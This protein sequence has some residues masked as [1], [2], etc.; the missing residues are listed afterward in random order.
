M[1]VY[2][3]Y[4]SG[5]HDQTYFDKINKQ[6]NDEKDKRMIINQLQ[7]Q[8]NNQKRNKNSIKHVKL[9]DWI[10]SYFNNSI[11]FQGFDSILFHDKFIIIINNYQSH[12]ISSISIDKFG[13][14]LYENLKLNP[15]S[16]FWPSCENLLPSYKNLNSRRALAITNLKDSSKLINTNE[17]MNL[18]LWDETN[19]GNL[20]NLMKLI[21]HQSSNYIGLQLLKLG[22]LQQHSLNSLFIDVIY[23]N[24]NNNEDDNNKFV[25]LLGEQLEQL[26]DP[27]LEYCPERVQNSYVP[28]IQ[29]SVSSI[30]NNSTIQSIIEELISVQTNYTI[31]LVNLLQNFIIPLRI[32]IVNNSKSSKNL[33]KIN[34]IFPPTI[35]EITRINCI[36]NDSLLKAQKINYLQVFKSLSIILPQFYKPFIRHEANVKKFGSELIKFYHHNKIEIFENLTINVNGLSIREIDSIITGSLLELSKI[37]LII[38]RL[39]IAI[40]SEKL[41]IRNFDQDINDTK[42]DEEIEKYSKII[43]E[44]IDA[45][46][47]ENKQDQEVNRDR[48]F[49]PSGKFLVELAT[50]W[51]KELQNGWI[52]RKLIGIFEMENLQCETKCN[53]EVLII[54]SDYLLILNISDHE[55]YESNKDISISIPDVLMHSLINE[56]PLPNIDRFPSMEVKNWCL[57]NE[58]LP[59]S[60]ECLTE[61][62]EIIDCLRILNTT[63]S[64]FNATEGDQVFTKHYKVLN[65]SSSNVI[66]LIIKANV[67][68]KVSPFHLFK[69]TDSNLNIYYTAHE[70]S[71]YVQE[72]SKSN[73]L[74]CLNMDIDVPS[75]FQSNPNLRFLLQISFIDEEKVRVTGYD[76]ICNKQINEVIQGKNLNEFIKTMIYKNF[77][78]LVSTYNDVTKNLIK[79]NEKSLRFIIDY[80]INDQVI[81]NVH[82]PKG[83]NTQYSISGVLHES[84]KN[85]ENK[86]VEQSKV[87]PPKTEKKR[88]SLFGNLFKV[89]Q[90]KI[91]TS[92]DSTNNISHT[93]IPRGTKK[94]YVDYYKP[95]PKLRTRADSNSSTITRPKEVSKLT[96]LLGKE[97]RYNSNLETINDNDTSVLRNEKL[98]KSNNHVTQPSIEISEGFSFPQKPIESE[99]PTTS[100]TIKR[101]STF[102]DVSLP[103]IEWLLNYTEADSQPN[104]E[105]ICSN[106]VIN[107]RTPI[108]EEKLES[109]ESSESRIPSNPSSI[110]SST[111]KQR[112]VSPPMPIIQQ[113]KREESIQSITSQ[114]YINHFEKFINFEFENENKPTKKDLQPFH[115]NNSIITLTSE[116][117]GHVN[118]F[119]DCRIFYSPIEELGK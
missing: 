11:V 54:F 2:K 18:P 38:E 31:G 4:V 37:K 109:S 90:V 3:R 76:K 108:I 67:L 27:L 78:G 82:L 9:K 102:D 20:A 39:I 23:D 19:A 43:F 85:L 81:E 50:K 6:P 104:W 1:S 60:Y 72:S 44:T 75:I 32:Y 48:I 96:S 40:E 68:H 45:F 87:S 110:F 12:K 36:L 14:R 69:F 55:Y 53:R 64:G 73:Y 5:E 59:S 21:K 58:A 111:Q 33:T 51:P 84:N 42:Q 17:I 93:F 56:K 114:Q 66:D 10:Q 41:K 22:L 80:V 119:T 70:C 35:D 8:F 92:N 52:S 79:S 28:P 89:K 61:N 24:N 88:K 65:G 62:Q 100:S 30:P 49:T 26:F 13:V 103:K 91:N 116:S 46:G 74:I 117:D 71:T 83:N 15:N 95:I 29:T 86:K 107:Q 47:Y 7:G 57:I 99:K 101:I 115:S 25:Y 34:Q 63:K 77:N 16:R 98:V 113:P 97:Q 106:K 105:L 118:S 112:K 94:E